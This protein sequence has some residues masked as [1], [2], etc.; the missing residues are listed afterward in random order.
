MRVRDH[1]SPVHVLTEM[2]KCRHFHFYPSDSGLLSIILAKVEAIMS[3]QVELAAELSNVTAHV[4]KIGTET[5]TLLGKIAELAAAIA[6][7]G[8][9][10]P[11]VDA[12]LAALQEQVIVVDD[13]VPD[14]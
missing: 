14:A 12:A 5:Q 2:S 11:E 4:A 7:A 6:T 10:T 1:R 8:N 13:L 3:T 9:T